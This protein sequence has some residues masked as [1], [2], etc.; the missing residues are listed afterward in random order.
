MYLNP[1]VR[2]ELVFR[3][4]FPVCLV[5]SLVAQQ[6]L[7]LRYFILP[8]LLTRIQIKPA[9]ATRLLVESILVSLINAFVFYLFLCRPFAWDQEPDK[10]QRFMW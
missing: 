9:S 1:N 5:L 8:F 10:V 2:S 6:L 7:E 3:V 4:L